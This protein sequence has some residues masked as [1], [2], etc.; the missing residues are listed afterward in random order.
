MERNENGLFVNPR[1]GNT[2][3]FGMTATPREG[4]G[5]SGGTGGSTMRGGCTG[6]NGAVMPR[7]GCDTGGCG[8]NTG[9]RRQLAMV[10]AP[11][12]C[13]RMLYDHSEALMRGTLFEELYKPLGVY[14]NE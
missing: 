7:E 10:Y 1:G 9:E 14:G 2:S 12:Q 5:R 8:C 6:N 11:M 4:C 13:F 3:G